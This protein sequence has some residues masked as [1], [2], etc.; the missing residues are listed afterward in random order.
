M[1]ED[2]HLFPSQQDDMASSLDNQMGLLKALRFDTR[3]ATKRFALANRRDRFMR[4]KLPFRG[5]GR[6]VHR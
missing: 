6:V 1:R 3:I 4:L 5:I 2:A